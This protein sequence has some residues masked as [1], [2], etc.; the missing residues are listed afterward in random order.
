VR[1]PGLRDAASIRDACDVL[2]DADWLRPPPKGEGFQ[3][4]GRI[5]YAVNPK[6]FEQ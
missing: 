5:A 4:R 1:L 6:V 3:S 2:V